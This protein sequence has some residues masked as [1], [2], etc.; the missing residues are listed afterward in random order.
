MSAVLDTAPV[1]VLPPDWKN[2]LRETL[3]WSTSIH[4]APATGLTQHA[5]TRE[6]PRRTLAFTCLAAAQAQRAVAIATAGRA[7]AR[8]RVPIWTDGQ[9]VA[10][11]AAGDEVIAC[12]TT[13]YDFAGP[14][15]A[16]LYRGPRDWEVV[17]VA[18]VVDGLLVLAAP[19][20]ADWSAGVQILPLRWARLQ[21]GARSLAVTDS[22]V[23]P[24]MIFLV[25]EPCAWP[26]QPPSVTYRGHPVLAS[27]PDWG[28]GLS[29][30]FDAGISDVDSGTALPFVADTRAPVVRSSTHVWEL[31]GR[32]EQ[33]AFRGL[34]YALHG[35]LRP[36][37][38]PTWSSD[39]RLAA[40]AGAG[41]SSLTVEWA[42]YTQ[43]GVGRVGMRDIR[44]ELWNGTALLRR[45]GASSE[46]LET[47]VLHVTEPLGVQLTPA[48]VRR[49]SFMA[50][51]T[52]ASDE[53]EIEHTADSDGRAR[54]VTAW[55]GVPD[56]V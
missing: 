20:L 46:G 11:V 6:W 12:R 33:R 30:S 44:I 18:H 28:E 21:P 49:I 4:R 1:W 37:W 34:I 53:V 26:A 54:A 52:L 56:D 45:V 29:S 47:E 36:I 32:E 3:A 5:S 25:D 19:V 42:G 48:Q 9:R 17:R 7:A 50:L 39:L 23:R 16:L 15:A 43:H 55:S 2:G 27:S 10:S 13:G 8:W 14:G 31:W 24:E 38:V 40:P 35:R 41:S 22:V 51:S